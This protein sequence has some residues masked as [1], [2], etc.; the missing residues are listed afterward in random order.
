MLQE[1]WRGKWEHKDRTAAPVVGLEQDLG[2]PVAVWRDQ[3]VP[4]WLRD[5]L[6][7]NQDGEK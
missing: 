2:A 6:T 4:S 1:I 5:V 3:R 7:K